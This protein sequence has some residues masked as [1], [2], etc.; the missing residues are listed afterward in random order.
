[1]AGSDP[2][3]GPGTQRAQHAAGSSLLRAWTAGLLLVATAVIAA[4]YRDYG[5]TWDEPVQS[6]YGEAVLAYFRGDLHE[7]EAAAPPGLRAYGPAFELVAA[8]LYAPWPARK[9]EIR[10]LLIATTA[11]L[12]VLAVIGTAALVSSPLAPIFASL[13]LIML[14]RFY[15]DAF[16]NSKDAPFAALFACAVFAICRFA[17]APRRLGAALLCGAA[18]G[19]SLAVRPGGLPIALLLFATAAGWAALRTRAP[20]AVAIGA[21][22]AWASAWIVMVA[23]WPWAH[24]APVANPLGAARTAFAFP[25]AFPVLFEGRTTMSDQLPRYYLLKYVL[26]TTPTVASLLA[27]VGLLRG[28]WRLR[29]RESPESLVT[30]VALLWLG[31]PLLGALVIR[32]NV[33]DGM[34]HALFVLPALAL[35]CGIGAGSLAELAPPG[36]PRRAAAIA[37]AIL[38]AAPIASLVRLHPYQTTYFNAWV[39]GL[40]GAAGRYETDYWLAS[41]KEAIEWVNARAA[42]RPGRPLE[43]LVAVD[44]YARDCAA[45]FLGPDVAI[46][47]VV[48]YGIPGEIPPP[49]AY[50]VS[51]TRYGFD[52][53]Y[54]G[55]PVVH[56]I[57][58]DGAV[59]SVIR[60]REAEP[61]DRSRRQKGHATGRLGGS[62]P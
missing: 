60:A 54:P 6:A 30:L 2:E 41:Y 1:M 9:Y 28:A 33:Y 16:N 12:A 22:V 15:G 18:I 53:S 10:H 62:G 32:P 47:E 29:D 26:I 46:R 7:P 55:S 50:Y 58:R 52:R 21:L 48:E 3:R 40:G 14:P 35:F 8:L 13:A 43:V 20:G 38:L 59:F 44:G 51:T 5:I 31:A 49:Y 19:A 57:G 25:K 27:G 56:A 39:G 42:L 37:L 4:T 17:L 11:L 61:P 34:R 24:E 36:R 23:F 45:R